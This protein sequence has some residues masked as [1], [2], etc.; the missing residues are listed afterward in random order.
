M[1]R[2]SIQVVEV[3]TRN[4]RL[5]IANPNIGRG[6]EGHTSK[7]WSIRRAAWRTDEYATHLSSQCSESVTHCEGIKTR[8]TTPREQGSW[9]RNTGGVGTGKRASGRYC[10][11]DE[12]GHQT[13][14]RWMGFNDV[15]K[16]VGNQENGNSWGTENKDC[17]VRID[18]LT[19]SSNQ[20]NAESSWANDC[21]NQSWRKFEVKRTRSLNR[22]L[23]GLDATDD[24]NHRTWEYSKLWITKVKPNCIGKV[25]TNL[26]RNG[27]RVS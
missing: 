14:Q 23:R 9:V 16:R 19:L 17:E 27:A 22:W 25:R 21:L 11:E 4:R 5:S 8:K 2:L 12:G 10:T 6:E 13:G 1:P 3:R 7:V 24:Q 18:Y 15:W 26:S 20:R